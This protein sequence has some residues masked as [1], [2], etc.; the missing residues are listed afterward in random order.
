MRLLYTPILI[1]VVGCSAGQE[2]SVAI[3]DFVFPAEVKRDT[4]FVLTANFNNNCEH[5]QYRLIATV[6]DTNR[7][8]TADVKL[9]ISDPNLTCPAIYKSTS[10]STEVILRNTGTYTLIRSFR[11]GHNQETIQVID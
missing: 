4:P 5:S 8:I 1:A 6:D 7:T 10:A 2:V 3:S 9:M 11:T